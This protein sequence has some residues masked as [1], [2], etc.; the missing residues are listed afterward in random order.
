M[1]GSP[2]RPENKKRKH[3][4]TTLCG[5]EGVS[6]PGEHTGKA[7]RIRRE[8]GHDIVKDDV[9]QDGASSDDVDDDQGEDQFNDLVAE[10]EEAYDNTVCGM[11]LADLLKNAAEREAFVKVRDTLANPVNDRCWFRF[12]QQS[13]PPAF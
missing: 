8:N 6:M 12:G 10:A 4:Y 9:Y 11:S 13:I 5:V 2:S 1:F 3:V 7:W